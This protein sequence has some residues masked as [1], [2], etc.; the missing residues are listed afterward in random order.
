MNDS[1]HERLGTNLPAVNSKKTPQNLRVIHDPLVG[2]HQQ[3]CL[4]Q[5][6]ITHL[7]SNT[8]EPAKI[9]HPLVVS[10][11]TNTY[12][13]RLGAVPA[14]PPRPPPTPSVAKNL[15]PEGKPLLPFNATASGCTPYEARIWLPAVLYAHRH[16][17]YEIT[18]PTNASSP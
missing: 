12:N 4:R 16:L 8:S 18:Q 3:T 7:S 13:S 14:E 15:E 5:K 17:P 6:A 10:A 11:C 1:K 9:D 2:I